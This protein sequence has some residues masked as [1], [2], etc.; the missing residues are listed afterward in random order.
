MSKCVSSTTLR[1]NFS[2]TLK[3]ISQNEKYLLITKKGRPVSAMVNLDFFE[4][5]LA[6]HSQ[7]YVNS[8]KEA[9][10]DYQNNSVFSHNEV[11]GSL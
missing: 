3:E 10:K 11:F 4:D 1:D 2:D 6:L 9:R 5:L 8:I 7:D